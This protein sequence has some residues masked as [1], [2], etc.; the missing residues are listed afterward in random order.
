MS[1]LATVSPRLLFL[2]SSLAAIR[3]DLW[4]GLWRHSGVVQEPSTAQTDGRGRVKADQEQC[5]VESHDHDGKAGLHVGG[6]LGRLQRWGG[7]TIS[8]NCL[9]PSGQVCVLIALI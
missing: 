8:S 3:G 7:N 9:I 2:V 1:A 6:C 5:H 4:A